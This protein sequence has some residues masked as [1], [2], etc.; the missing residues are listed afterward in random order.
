MANAIIDIQIPHFSVLDERVI[1]T[2]P[3]PARVQD[4]YSISLLNLENII[5]YSFL[6]SD[7]RVRYSVLPMAQM[8]L[9]LM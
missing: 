1:R 2:N 4:K 6:C 9:L 5:F 3:V 7:W 8:Y